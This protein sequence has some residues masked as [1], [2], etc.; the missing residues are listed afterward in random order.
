MDV[1]GRWLQGGFPVL[2]FPI[3]SLRYKIGFEAHFWEESGK[4][5]P[6]PLPTRVL[7]AEQRFPAL[8]VPFRRDAI[9]EEKRASE[10]FP[11]AN[12]RV[13]MP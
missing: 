10:S 5:F 13:S 7:A 9:L 1:V 4:G 11:S 3:L 6:V 12:P 8:D 2:D